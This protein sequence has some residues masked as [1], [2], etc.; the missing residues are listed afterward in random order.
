MSTRTRRRNTAENELRDP[1]ARTHG[2]L[3]VAVNTRA[4][5]SVG[6][7]APPG[8]N[9]NPLALPAPPRRAD[10]TAAAA[11]IAAAATDADAV[12]A[13]RWRRGPVLVTLRV[14][15]GNSS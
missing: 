4:P 1:S 6:P 3:A 8:E 13:A 9:A 7:R 2:V 15:A 10:A 14:Y 5:V 11:V 12:A